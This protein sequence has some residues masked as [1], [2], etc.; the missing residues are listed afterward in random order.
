MPGDPQKK[1]RWAAGTKT[2]EKHGFPFPTHSHE[3]LEGSLD[4]KRG[5]YGRNS[6]QICKVRKMSEGDQVERHAPRKK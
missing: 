6:R 1:K 5:E 4:D 2:K 3:G